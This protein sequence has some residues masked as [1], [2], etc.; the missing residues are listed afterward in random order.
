MFTDYS[1]FGTIR[2]LIGLVKDVLA[3]LHESESFSTPS[4]DPETRVW[5][6]YEGVAKEHDE[7]FLEK[8]NTS[9]DSLLI[10]ASLFSA[11]SSAFIVQ[12]Q[13]SLS[14]D[15]SDTTN[16]LLMIVAHII[17]ATIF[18]NQPLVLT[19]STGPETSVVWAQAFGYAS[20]SMSLLAAFGA[21]IGKQ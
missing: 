7:E 5:R 14:P 4:R 15:P 8:H 9:L 2:R 3:T 17:N 16:E 6:S 19:P 20:P 18:P 1:Q 10:F 12:A 21:V 13:S 11:V